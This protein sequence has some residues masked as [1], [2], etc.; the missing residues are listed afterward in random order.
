MNTLATDIQTHETFLD[1]CPRW[2]RS[3][4]HGPFE[5]SFP[6]AA[7]AAAAKARGRKEGRE[8]ASRTTANSVLCG[9]MS[10][11]ICQNGELQPHY[12][13]RF[14]E[15]PYFRRTR[16]IFTCCVSQ[17][18]QSSFI[19][20]S[21]SLTFSFIPQKG[22]SSLMPGK[23]YESKTLCLSN[24]SLFILCATVPNSL[25]TYGIKGAMALKAFVH[26]CY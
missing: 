11:V 23:N 14:D 1:A 10:Q 19:I 24:I 26:Y 4:E 5:N 20:V 8:K 3:N 7:N 21:S 22:H 18:D 9:L 13:F 12:N 16:D 2:I 15:G 25:P 17:S 6:P